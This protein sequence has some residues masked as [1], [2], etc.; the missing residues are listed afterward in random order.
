MA[1]IYGSSLEDQYWERQLDKYLDDRD[2]VHCEHCEKCFPNE[3][4]FL[5]DEDDNHICPNCK[6][7]IM[8]W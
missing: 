8:D 1:G 2:R 7:I 4:S 5:V 6:Q 3:M